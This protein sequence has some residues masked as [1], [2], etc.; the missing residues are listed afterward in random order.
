MK[1][2]TSR[3]CHCGSRKKYRD[4]CGRELRHEGKGIAIL[5]AERIP[6]CN[7]NCSTDCAE[8]CCGGA[9]LITMDEIKNCYDML[10]IT[11]GFRKYL[12][13]SVKHRDFLRT[14]GFMSDRFYMVG[15]FIAGNRH[16][17]RCRALG[18]DNLCVLH[19]EKRKP[20]QCQIVP[21]CA[22]YPEDVR[23]IVF[24]DQKHSKF[25]N[26]K[27]FRSPQ[28]T[29]FTVWKEGRFTDPLIRNAFYGYQRGLQRQRPIMQSILRTL[30]GQRAYEEFRK[31]EGILEVYIPAPQLFAV[32]DEAG[33]SMEE[34]H[35][36]LSF[37]GRLC[38]DELTEKQTEN[39]V[40]RDYL[41]A[42]NKIAE[43][44]AKFIKN[45]GLFH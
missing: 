17:K 30:E 37:Q 44:Y 6:V 16:G 34:S 28:E 3:F 45:Q 19:K 15:D 23:D 24:M 20:R 8:W 7:F 41:A 10:P 33:F 5:N 43:L 42:L 11:I 18:S 40:L 13:M 14:V 36:F 22:L 9:T 31:G 35:H 1:N 12:P 39:P 32:L 29:D 26:C 2:K 27:G 4:C 38:Y 25:S 21:F